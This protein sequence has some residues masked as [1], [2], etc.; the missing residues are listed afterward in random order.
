[1]INDEIREIT[2]KNL[3]IEYDEIKFLIAEYIDAYTCDDKEVCDYIRNHFDWLAECAEGPCFT[4]YKSVAK[5]LTNDYPAMLSNNL[6]YIV[7]NDET[8]MSRVTHVLKT[9]APKTDVNTLIDTINYLRKQNENDVPNFTDSITNKGYVCE[10][11]TDHQRI[12][13]YDTSGSWLESV[14][15]EIEEIYTIKD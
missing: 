2:A 9:N 3:D 7:L 10:Y 6:R 4:T 12:S 11:I 14:Y 1:M 13:L 5:R 15:P 8:G